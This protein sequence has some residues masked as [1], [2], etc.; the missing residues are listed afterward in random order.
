VKEKVALKME[1]KDKDF[2]KIPHRM[3]DSGLLSQ[4]K[5][6]VLKVFLVI[7]R[8]A[9][10]QTGVAYP[11]VEK[12][13]ELS[14]VNKNSIAGATKSLA[15][16]GLIEKKKTGR[17]FH[18]RNCY[19]VT[20]LKGIYSD[21]PS[22]I[23]PKK[24]DKCR[25]IPRGKDGKFIPIPKKTDNSIPQNTDNPGPSFADSGTCPE[26][27]DKKENLEISKRDNGFR[28]NIPSGVSNETQDSIDEKVDKNRQ[29]EVFARTP[30]KEPDPEMVKS[31]ISKHGVEWTRKYLRDNGYDEKS[32][33]K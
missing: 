12:I 6:T 33:E 2:S 31:M 4:L 19:R 22:C 16:E 7:N 3:I 1:E 17:R 10:Y 32:A 23:I 26:N 21:L 11:T 28:D 5:P 24:T 27:T 15:R 9:D 30:L 18:F 14:G 25:R 13:S 8:F 20:R 29:N